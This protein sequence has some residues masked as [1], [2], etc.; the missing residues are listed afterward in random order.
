MSDFEK[1]KIKKTSIQIQINGIFISFCVDI[2]FV[3]HS[4][5]CFVHRSL[6][7][8]YSSW[9][10][11]KWNRLNEKHVIIIELCFF[12]FQMSTSPPNEPTYSPFDVEIAR[13]KI[14]EIPFRARNFLNNRKKTEP[15]FQ[16]N[17]RN[18][19]FYVVNGPLQPTQIES[20]Y[21]HVYVSFSIET[22]PSEVKKALTFHELVSDRLP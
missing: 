9:K 11:E 10:E 14:E 3:L 12:L 13:T 20:Y 1:C 4:T 6:Q 21:D 22:I 18:V 15:T 16:L 8:L 5:V 7:E 2:R 19:W 17:Q